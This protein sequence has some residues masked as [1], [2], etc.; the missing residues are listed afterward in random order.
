ML[1]DPLACRL[2]SNHITDVG[3]KLVARLV[4]ECPRLRVLKYVST[5][6]RSESPKP[7]KVTDPHSVL[8]IGKNQITPVGGRFLASAIQKSTSIFDV[9]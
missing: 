1:V 9:G 6:P 5:P 8:R 7:R 3:A 2:Y 4:E